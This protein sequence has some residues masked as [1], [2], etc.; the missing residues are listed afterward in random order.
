MLQRQGQLESDGSA[1]REAPQAAAARSKTKSGSPADFLRGVKS[2]LRKVAWPDKSEVTNYST[3]VFVALVL[4]LFMIFGMNYLFGHG[5][6]LLFG[7]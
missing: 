2:E 3:V 7:T 5:V 6:N 4:L 1:R